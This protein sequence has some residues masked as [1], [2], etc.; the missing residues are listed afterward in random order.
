METNP[1]RLKAIRCDGCGREVA[2]G[3]RDLLL[4]W[5]VRGIDWGPGDTRNTNVDLCGA[6]ALQEAAQ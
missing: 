4:H 3:S 1:Q 6:C 5:T 2:P